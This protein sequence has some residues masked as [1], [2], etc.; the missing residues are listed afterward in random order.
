MLP[1]THNHYAIY[2]HLLRT[3][4]HISA[5]GHLRGT[6]DILK[7]R[8]DS[9]ESFQSPHTKKAAAKSSLFL[10]LKRMVL[11]LSLFGS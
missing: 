1:C 2:L 9:S 4:Q 7:N 10:Q 5:G 11:L 3:D 8:F 6:Y